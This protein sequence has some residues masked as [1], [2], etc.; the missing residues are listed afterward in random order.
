MV[1]CIARN[2]ACALDI[3]AL[4]ASR[5]ISQER[6]SL[7]K[8]M[9]DSHLRPEGHDGG[10]HDNFLSRPDTPAGPEIHIPHHEPRRH[11]KHRKIVLCFDGTGNKFHGDDSDSNI[12]KIFRMLDRTSSYQ[13]TRSFPFFAFGSLV[14]RGSTNQSQITTTSVSQ[15]SFFFLL[16]HD[17]YQPK[18]E[19]EH[20]S[21]PKTSRTRAPWK[22]LSPGTKK[23]KI[24]PSARLLTSML[25]AA[26][27]F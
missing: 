5:E 23:P 2:S 25:S 3:K 17:A 16:M 11:R 18:L 27:A 9:E 21:S 1:V 4:E 15:P 26:I 20:M 13:C 22:S 19:L 7:R 14:A 12:L 8:E 10:T 24:P 6:S